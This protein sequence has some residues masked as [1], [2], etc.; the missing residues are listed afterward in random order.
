MVEGYKMEKNENKDDTTKMTSSG[1]E[2][3]AVLAVLGIIGLVTF[4]A[5]KKQ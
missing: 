5:R 4:G 2:W 3:L 1:I